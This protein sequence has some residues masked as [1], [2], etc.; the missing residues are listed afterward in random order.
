M[1]LTSGTRLGPYE[2]IAPLGAG[3]MGEVYRARDSRLDRIVAVKVLNSALTANADLKARF[4]REAK[5]I[6]ALQDPHICTLFD[7]GHQDGTDFLV[8]E[9]L[10]GETL[11]DRLRRGPMPLEQLVK[12]GNEIA[13]AL[14]KA[15]RAGIVHRDLKPGNVMLTKSGAKLLDFGLAKPLSTGAAAS[16]SNASAP[17]LSAAVTLTNGS[18]QLSPLT[19]QGS[20]VGTIQYMSPEQI[21]GKEADACSDIFA[22]GAVLYEMAT[23]KRAF[24][25]KSQLTVA[26]AI[27]DKEPERVTSVLPS[28]PPALD[29]VI[30][31]CL[32]K[33]PEE[34][35]QS[36]RDVKLDLSWV[37]VSPLSSLPATAPAIAPSKRG[38]ERIAWIAAGIALLIAAM[39]VSFMLFR[40]LPRPAVLRATLLPPKGVAI[41]PTHMAVSPDGSRVVFVGVSENKDMLWQRALNATEAQ[42]IPGT[43]GAQYPFW[44]PDGRSIGFFST[45]KLRKVDP[46]SG[47]TA[48]L[49]DAPSGRG[50][51]WSEKDTIV[52]SADA[53]GPLYQVSST[54]GAVTP[55]TQVDV[56][57]GDNGHRWPQFLPGGRYLL[58]WLANKRSGGAV[59]GDPADKRSG[60][61][62]LDLKTGQHRLLLQTDSGAL[63]AAGR[64]LYI[65][66][67]SLLAQ[68]FDPGSGKLTGSP[69]TIARQVVYDNDRWIGGFAAS[70]S[71]PLLYVGGNSFGA[72]QL[73][74]VDRAGKEQGRV[75]EAGDYFWPV[76]SPDAQRAAVSDSSGRNLEVWVI[77][78]TRGTKTR[79]T[80]DDAIKAF[81]TWSPDGLRIA[82]TVAQPAQ[83]S[84]IY[85]KNAS[86]IGEAEKLIEGPI[87]STLSTMDW[88][89]DN[90][91]LI[92]AVNTGAKGNRLWVYWFNEKKSTK[93][94]PEDFKEWNAKFSPDGKWLAYRSRESGQ[95]EVYVVPFPKV[96]GKWQVSTAGGDYPRWNRNGQEIFYLAPNGMLMSVAINTTGGFKPGLPQPMFVTTLKSLAGTQ[97]D[98]AP[99]GKFLLNRRLTGGTAEPITVV[100]NW[101]AELKK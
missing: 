39:L 22:F 2:I 83:P 6:S 7:V 30:R 55:L 16:G 73:T 98:V 50:G 25:G 18:P 42:L 80:F 63:Y 97:Y 14:D 27:L 71:G 72:S 34:R 1:A 76:I 87:N 9:F 24:E 32:A 17:L 49:A 78:F 53:T 56:T 29:H 23:G 85:V 79:L 90:R 41:L 92:Y 40:P 52:F 21:E 44:S 64:L 66:Q 37:A 70:E 69:E 31:T 62:L 48:T 75:G 67:D 46:A 26:S 8:M 43:E 10:E 3:G 54:G 38:R 12:T 13:E 82:Y 20:I 33:N 45:D 77:D 91:A 89:P 88:S 101:T 51:A 74:W 47:T 57:E 93:L 86:G 59:S 100:T 65:W 36:A 11:A 94:L 96:D 95:D 35:Y 61:F 81:P 68:P 99:D 19:T 4:E 60:E 84:A 15:H 58:F 28:A 5:A